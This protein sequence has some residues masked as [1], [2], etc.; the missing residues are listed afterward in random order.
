M[1]ADAHFELADWVD[2]V[3]Q[4]GPA[5]RLA[6]M[7][8]HLVQDRCESCG[9]MAEMLAAA[10]GAVREWNRVV[11]PDHVVRRAEAV[12]ETPERQ[13]WWESA[14][15]PGRW[16]AEAMAPSPALVG[17]RSTAMQRQR[18]Y[19]STV[20]EVRLEEDA[21]PDGSRLMIGAVTR[22]DGTA[23]SLEGMRV[24]LVAGRQTLDETATNPFGEFELTVP[25]NKAARM[26]VLM[27]ESGQRLELDFDQER[28]D[29]VE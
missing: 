11:V 21:S 8:N 25:A 13:A 6:A 2:Y 23:A 10:Y 16:L 29:V 18:T 5:E 26:V 19:R 1:S 20:W 12:F 14:L 15:L 28:L 9:R 3:R 22:T 7:E 24:L 4:T 27:G 17:V